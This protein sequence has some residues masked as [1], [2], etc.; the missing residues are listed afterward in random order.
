MAAAVGFGDEEEGGKA[1]GAAALGGKE[2]LVTSA[3]T[4]AAITTVLA[5]WFV[6]S[7]L[8]SAE[9]AGVAVL[10]CVATTAYLCYR[11]ESGWRGQQ[12]TGRD[13]STYHVGLV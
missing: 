7:A 8:S 11:V 5:C 10:L 13:N 9:V 12:A 4:A 2:E 3:F 6:G 1:G